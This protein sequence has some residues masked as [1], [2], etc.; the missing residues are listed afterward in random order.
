MS[1]NALETIVLG[2]DYGTDSCRAVLIDAKDG[3]EVASAVA[4]YPRWAEGRYCDPARNRFRQHPLDYTESLAAVM[5]AIK[6]AHR[7]GQNHSPSREE[8]AARFQRA[9]GTLPW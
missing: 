9:F 4:P 2:I 8:I 7:G 3:R 1:R 6:I 5:G